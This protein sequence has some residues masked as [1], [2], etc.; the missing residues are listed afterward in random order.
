VHEREDEATFVIEGTLSFKIGDVL[1]D[2]GPGAFVWAPRGI[3]HTFA[4][5]TDERVRVLGT[6]V[7]AGLEGMFQEQ[8]A[9]FA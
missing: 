4:N 8:I 1:F 2:A 5:R 6:I 9:H 7:P 3:P